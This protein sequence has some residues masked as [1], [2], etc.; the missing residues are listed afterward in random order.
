MSQY[1]NI[2]RS[3]YSLRGRDWIK[4]L[5]VEDLQVFIDIGLQASDHGKMGGR[6]LVQRHG[7]EHMRKIA[8]I[9]AI[10]TN[11]IKAWNKAMQ[12]ELLKLGL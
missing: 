8:R 11:S 5:P 10:A 12:D 4:A 2:F 6:A 9:G 7:K 3:R 1:P